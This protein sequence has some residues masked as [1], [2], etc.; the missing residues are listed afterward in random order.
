MSYNI[1][2]FK[3]YMSKESSKSVD[4]VLQSGFI[5]QGPK[6]DEFESELRK[7]FKNDYVV[8]VNSATSAEHLALHMIKRPSVHKNRLNNTWLGLE[9]GDEVL[10]TPLTCTATNF[11]ILANNLNIK[12]HFQFFYLL[13]CTEMNLNF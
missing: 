9:D 1:P 13:G 10:A 8:T 11:P 7:F 12:C 5:G 2:L 3:V 4:D 6:V